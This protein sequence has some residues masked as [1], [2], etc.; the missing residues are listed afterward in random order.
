MGEDCKLAHMH[1]LCGMLF[2]AVVSSTQALQST[3]ELLALHLTKLTPKEPEPQI[4]E[5]Y[6]YI[7]SQK[8]LSHIETSRHQSHFWC[9]RSKRDA[10]STHPKNTTPNERRSR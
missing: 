9:S 6:R 4:V 10:N 5:P 8:D 3:D 7:N 2:V 1:S